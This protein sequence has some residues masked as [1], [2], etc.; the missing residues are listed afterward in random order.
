MMENGFMETPSCASVECN[1][2]SIEDREITHDLGMPNPDFMV[3]GQVST[4]DDCFEDMKK[5]TYAARVHAK[6]VDD[7]DCEDARYESICQEL[8]DE[9]RI[10]SEDDCQTPKYELIKVILTH[11]HIIT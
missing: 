3:R 2:P 5:V 9:N 6:I 11:T 7:V 1:E 10:V 8:I 4:M